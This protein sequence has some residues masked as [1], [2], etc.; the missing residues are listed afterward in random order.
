MWMAAASTLIAACEG[1]GVDRNRR[2]AERAAGV[3]SAILPELV[4]L[5][6]MHQVGRGQGYAPTPMMRCSVAIGTVA[7]R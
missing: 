3:L 4:A 5:T 7:S 2:V 6:T 1:V